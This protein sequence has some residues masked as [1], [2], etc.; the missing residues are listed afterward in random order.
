MAGFTHFP[1]LL[2]S[3]Y[4]SPQLRKL[5]NETLKEEKYDIIHCET[6]YVTPN[7]P[8]TNIPILLVEQ[9]IEYLVYQKFV[10]DFKLFILKPL[11]YLDVFKLKF[12]EEHLWK[13]VTKLATVSEEDRDFIRKT[14]PNIKVEVIAN[15][16]DI[17]YFDKI[18]KMVNKTPTV[19]FIGQF[20]WLPNLD[21]AIFL[22][23]DIW[24][25]IIKQI[26][27]AKLLIVGRDPTKEVI[28]FNGKNNIQVR[29]D[30]EDI[31]MVYAVADVLVAPIRNGK[32]TK[33]K[34][35]E[36]MATKTP[37]VGTPLAVSG[38]DIK[39]G[40]HALIGL[41]EDELASLTIKIL[42]NKKL[43]RKIAENAYRLAEIEYG[44]EKVMRKLNE[45]YNN[46]IE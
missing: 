11:M 20:K 4:Y 5:I 24:P 7:V 46:M 17:R 10:K 31:R 44:W 34:V 41:D 39:N 15:G 43:A 28:M 12:W 8:K 26:P 25:K 32:G 45:V 19:I 14:E 1:F 21:A 29:S 33:Y 3:T 22:A 13:H 37:I 27:E 2:I 30:I 18:T 16:V 23:E 9:T 38:L 40:V 6:F 42:R 35:I 36:A